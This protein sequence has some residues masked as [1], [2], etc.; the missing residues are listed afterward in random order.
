MRLLS[1]AALPPEV[2]TLGCRGTWARVKCY[3]TIVPE[4]PSSPGDRRDSVGDGE[5]DQGGNMAGLTVDAEIS[6]A[7]SGTDDGGAFLS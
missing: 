6:V 7:D 3:S 1:A 2:V 4:V 5:G